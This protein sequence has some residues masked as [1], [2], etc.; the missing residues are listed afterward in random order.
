MPRVLVVDDEPQVRELLQSVLVGAGFE[1]ETA[2]DGVDA[3]EK[4]HSMKSQCVITDLQMPRM[5]GRKFADEIKRL[6]PQVPVIMMTGN[7]ELAKEVKVFEIIEK[8]IRKFP[9]FVNLIKLVTGEPM[10]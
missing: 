10:R 3:L 2:E 8:P 6:F 5:D 1:V 9:E 4:M 7:P